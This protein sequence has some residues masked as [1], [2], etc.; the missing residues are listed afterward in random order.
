MKAQNHPGMM[1]KVLKDSALD[2]L[3]DCGER[4]MRQLIEQVHSVA[5]H[6]QLSSLLN[7]HW[8]STASLDDLQLLLELNYLGDALDKIKA[9]SGK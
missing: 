4:H 8:S 7:T 1:R 5:R 3:A 6:D 9:S 2:M